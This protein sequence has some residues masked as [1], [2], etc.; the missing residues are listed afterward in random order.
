MSLGS[1]PDDI[2]VP[3]VWIDIDNSQALELPRL[4]ALPQKPR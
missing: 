2:R 3:L 1:I 4:K